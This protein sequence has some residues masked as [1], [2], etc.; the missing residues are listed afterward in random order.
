MT[1]FPYPS[2]PFLSSFLS[3][4]ASVVLKDN[5]QKAVRCYVYLK[6]LYDE[7]GCRVKDYP[8]SIHF[9]PSGESVSFK[10]SDFFKQCI[11]LVKNPEIKTLDLTADLTQSDNSTIL[12]QFNV[13]NLLFVNPEDEQDWKESIKKYYHEL[14]YTEIEDLLALF[15]FK[16]DSINKLIRIDFRNTLADK[17]WIIPLDKKKGTYSKIAQEELEEKLKPY[18]DTFSSATQEETGNFFPNEF[19][20]KFIRKFS[21]VNDTR[22]LFESECL[23]SDN[24]PLAKLDTIL[25]TLAQNWF[26]VPQTKPIQLSYQEKETQTVKTVITYPVTFVYI[27]RTFYLYGIESERD[28]WQAYR[29]DRIHLAEIL[30]W[31]DSKV[32]QTLKTLL[33]DD[34]LPTIDEIQ[35]ELENNALGY[36]FWKTPKIMLLQFEKHHYNLHIKSNQRSQIFREIN[37][38]NFEDVYKT[39]GQIIPPKDKQ[40]TKQQ[41]MSILKQAQANSPD[42]K[43]L[44]CLA[45]YYE[46]EIAVLQRLLAWGKKVKVV[47]P[48]T[49]QQEILEELRSTLKLYKLNP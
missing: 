31:N 20:T 34:D 45:T 13:R 39:A 46:Q 49:L 9:S 2:I 36:A 25:N 10:P 37:L 27:K 15:P 17:Q 38:N 32:P 42:N 35:D 16:K 44:F 33:D 40:K 29:I 14:R 23:V 19:I 47:F 3:S 6:A 7:A 26:N 21:P 48:E 8:Y 12:Q 28:D 41:I 22:I 11:Q 18:Q 1:S 4:Q 5:F 24:I 30:D 43:Y